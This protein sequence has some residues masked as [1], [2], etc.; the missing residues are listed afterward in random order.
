M[1]FGKGLELEKPE[2]VSDQDFVLYL[3]C[4]LYLNYPELAFHQIKA[5]EINEEFYEDYRY[6]S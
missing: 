1:R 6:I 2:G 3:Y 4:C 5:D